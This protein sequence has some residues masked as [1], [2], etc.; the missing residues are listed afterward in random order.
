MSVLFLHQKLGGFSTIE[1]LF[2]FTFA[3]IFLSGAA[4]ISFAG[5]TSSLDVSLSNGGINRTLTQIHT[6]VA[7]TTQ[8]WNAKINYQ[9]IQKYI[10]TDIISSISPCL[11][12]IESN[13]TWTT[14]HLRGQHVLLNSYLGSTDKAQ[15]LGGGCDPFP[16]LSWD[17]PNS[18]GSVD[19]VG[20]DATG[21]A[22]RSV[23]NNIYAFI[24]ADPIVLEGKDF[25]VVNVTDATNPVIQGVPLESLKGLNGIA[26][27][28]SYAYVIHN[29]NT[30]QLLTIDVHDPTNPIE[31]TRARRTFPNIVSS[32]SPVSS[33]CL[34]GR[35]ITYY[36]GRLYIGTS[37][38]A[39]GT[40]VQN[41]ELQIYC[42]DDG[43]TSGCTPTTPVWVGSY[44]VNHNV[45]DIAVQTQIINGIKKTIAYLAVSASSA[46]ASE[47][48]TFDVTKPSNVSLLGSFNPSG[49][50]YG[51]S[52]YLLDDTAYLGRNQSTGTNKDFYLLNISNPST[53]IE[54]SSLKLGIASN[55]FVS[56]IIV[57]GTFAF[58]ATTDSKKPLLI[59]NVTDSENPIPVSTC[60]MQNV[61][62]TSDVA[63]NEN[64]LFTV[65]RS[66]DLLR[67]LYDH[68]S[69]C[70]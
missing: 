14:E 5:Q 1:L 28:N 41:H 26:V 59:F 24:T 68:P 18:Q 2:A 23:D 69:T 62:S 44:N 29:S 11:K 9:P 47:F 60:T 7:S 36:E 39:F 53:P 49:T 21:I 16:P 65:N 43:I 31:I 55:T 20:S 38:I 33:P 37:Y 3:T 56:A 17:N 34:S 32:C 15:A 66:G 22:V 58:V 42:V 35:S 70:I 45:N 25:I 57:Q 40:S 12:K 61:Q 46:S 6:A 63:Y 4:L 64:K 50:D 10:Q 19:V 30:E 27:A 52:V 48:L 51:W 67:I 8:N 13:T 54:R